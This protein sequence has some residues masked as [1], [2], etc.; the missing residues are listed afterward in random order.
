MLRIPRLLI[1]LFVALAL[2][3]IAGVAYAQEDLTPP[4]LISVSFEP[5]SID[6]SAAD[7]V[8]TMTVV[9]TDD[10]SGVA[11]GQIQLYNER[12]DRRYSV[13]FTDSLA[14]GIDPQGRFVVE[15]VLP[16]YTP[17]GPYSMELYAI[18]DVVGNSVMVRRPVTE[19]EKRAAGEQWPSIFNGVGLAVVSGD[20]PRAVYLPSLAR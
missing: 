8:I 4:T 18:R 6:T 14:D 7:A 10:L 15:F 20:A 1:A 9:V 12:T 2:A 3:G 16:R 11:S 5:Q 19:E 17:Y 13:P